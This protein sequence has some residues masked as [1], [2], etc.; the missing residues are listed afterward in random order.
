MS[1][2]GISHE[3]VIMVEGDA[4]EFVPKEKSATCM[5]GF[6]VVV[7]PRDTGEWIVNLVWRFTMFYAAI[8]SSP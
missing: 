6:V 7:P 4:S 5:Q 8:H 2:G 1:E 3:K